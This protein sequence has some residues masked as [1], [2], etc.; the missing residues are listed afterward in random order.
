MNNSTGPQISSVSKDTETVFL[1]L[2]VIFC[3][4]L[5]L[6]LAVQWSIYKIRLHTSNNY[7]LIRALS[8]A[9]SLAIVLLIFFGLLKALD[10]SLGATALNVILFS[11]LNTSYSMSLVITMLIVTD[12]WIAM[13]FALRYH[14]LVTK[15]KINIAILVSSITA[16]VVDITLSFSV[17]SGDQQ[18]RMVPSNNYIMTLFC[19]LRTITCVYIIIFAKRTLR[20]RSQNEARI[21]NI[22]NF[23]GAE[24][25]R[26][27]IM[28][29]LTRSIKDV[30]ALNIGT[31]VFLLPT[32][33]VTLF[34]DVSFPQ[35]MN[36]SE[37]LLVFAV[38]NGI[39]LISNPI[40]YLLCFT[41]I[42]Q[43]WYRTLI[44]RNNVVNNETN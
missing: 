43:Y 13:Q 24:A 30:W 39:Y 11:F 34:F 17:A 7:Y 6:H 37:R 19:L 23:H 33:V 4:I 20:V 31:S 44:S 40:V 5:C 14:A 9:D 28:K 35:M 25:E 1:V 38:A 26:L 10:L 21:Q 3:M 2:L 27:V 41:K 8:L 29:R 22:T 15:G 12:R 16:F 18:R 36:F 42:R 32:I